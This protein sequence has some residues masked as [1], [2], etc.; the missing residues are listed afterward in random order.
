MP[1]LKTKKSVVKKERYR[2]K[3][4]FSGDIPSKTITI[5][6]RPENLKEKNEATNRCLKQMPKIY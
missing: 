1:K 5:P 3:E 6:D 4:K 2:E